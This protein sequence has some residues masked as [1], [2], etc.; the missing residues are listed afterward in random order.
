M[1]AYLSRMR[2]ESYDSLCAIDLREPA[3]AVK[4]KTMQYVTQLKLCTTIMSLPQ[5]L[6]MIEEQSKEVDK[7]VV[8]MKNSQEGG[9]I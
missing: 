1:L 6:K 2:Q 7:K 5:V 9:E 8:Q 3:E 4:T